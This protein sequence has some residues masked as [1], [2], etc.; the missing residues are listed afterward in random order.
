MTPYCYVHAGDN[1]GQASLE[2]MV[3]V[4]SQDRRWFSVG[5]VGV[6]RVLGFTMIL[7]LAACEDSRWNSN[8]EL[9]KELQEFYQVAERA[10]GPGATTYV[11]PASEYDRIKSHL[12]VILRADFKS[13]TTAEHNSRQYEVTT[14][15]IEFKKTTRHKKQCVAITEKYV[16]RASFASVKVWCEVFSYWTRWNKPPTHTPGE[17]IVWKNDWYDDKTASVIE[18]IK[19]QEALRE[20]LGYTFSQVSR[21]GEA[22]FDDKIIEIE[23]LRSAGPKDPKR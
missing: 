6:L 16:G 15:T 18:S 5:T 20:K 21:I 2:K 9:P 8:E 7:L 1:I 3:S 22:V 4:Y 13:V 12:E 19:V 11:Y 14:E 17:F 23:L 10:S